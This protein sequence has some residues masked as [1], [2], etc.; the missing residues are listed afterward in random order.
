MSTASNNNNNNGSSS[1][2]F[3]AQMV[4]VGE[5]ILAQ[6]H[7]A[8]EATLD[9]AS[10]DAY[11]DMDVIYTDPA[12]GAKLFCGNVRAAMSR[13]TLRKFDVALVV[14]AQGPQSTNFFESDPSVRYLRIPVAFWRTN[15]LGAS[16]EQVVAWFS[17]LFEQIDAALANGESVLIHCLAGAHRAATTSAAY[18]RHRIKLQPHEAQLYLRK[19]RPI[20]ELLPGLYEVLLRLDD[21]LKAVENARPTEPTTLSA[22]L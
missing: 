5:E 3:D 9:E 15:L 12:T 2:A 1:N 20:V 17:P 16:H 18:L 7:D 4:Q 21:A 10:P 6:H 8:T 14:N 11:H 13:E 22:A 19:R